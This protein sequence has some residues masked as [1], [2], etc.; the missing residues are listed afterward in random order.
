VDLCM[1]QRVGILDPDNILLQPELL[2][3]PEHPVRQSRPF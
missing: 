2:R 3:G 1:T